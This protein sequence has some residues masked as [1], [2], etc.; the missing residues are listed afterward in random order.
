VD[1]EAIMRRVEA[2][3]ETAQASLRAAQG[4]VNELLTVREGLRL[5]VER[6]SDELTA[7]GPTS[8]TE[9][10][11]SEEQ[12]RTETLT[13]V[14]AVTGVGTPG[15]APSINPSTSN[16]AGSALPFRQADACMIL[17]EQAGRPL[18]TREVFE[19]MQK[20]GRPENHEQVRS[21]LTYLKRVRR[22]RRVGH[23]WEINA[24]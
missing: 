15:A 8:L 12:E 11:A 10:P 23:E 21:A 9:S 20:A 16:G 18:T 17:L 5:A 14:P 4:R 7:S 6:Y 22:I 2:D 1:I 3:L 13:L 19:R 24:A